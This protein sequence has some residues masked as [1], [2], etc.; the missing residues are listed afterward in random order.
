MKRKIGRV[1]VNLTTD[2]VLT[3]SVRISAL[4]R[5]VRMGRHAEIE[6]FRYLICQIAIC[7]FFFWLAARCRFL[8]AFAFDLQV[9]A[10]IA[11]F[12]LVTKLLN[13]PYTWQG[14]G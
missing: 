3:R 11:L 2:F 13:D 4:T 14:G 7:K 9:H 8:R 6:L 12:L 10:L 1:M 5:P